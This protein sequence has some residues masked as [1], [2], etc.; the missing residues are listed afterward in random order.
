MKQHQ[1]LATLVAFSLCYFFNLQTILGQKNIS[2]K[3]ITATIDS[4][5]ADRMTMTTPGA[6][7]IILQGEKV[8]LSKDYG[9]ANLTFGV[10]FNENTVFPLEGLTEQ[11]VVFSILQLEKKKQLNLD[12]SVNKYLPELGFQD[13]V[14]LSHLLNHSSDLPFIASLRL[15]AGWKFSD[16]FTQEDF[17]NFTKKFSSNLSPDKE[18]RHS[19]SGIKILQMV[20]EKVAGRSFSEY[21]A[22]HIFAPL[23]MTNSTVKVENSIESKNSAVGY[24]KTDTGYLNVIVTPFEAHS[25]HTY[26]TRL[27]FQKWMAN[28]QSK[29]FEGAIFER[30]DESLFI[31]GKLQERSN[32][33]YCLGQH[34]YWK[35]LG[36][37]EFY[38][39]E[40]GNGFSWKWTRSTQSETSIMVVGNLDSYIGSKVNAIADLLVDYDTPISSDRK[41]TESAPLALSKRE[42]EACTGFYWNEDYL[43]TTEISIKDGQLYHSD[44]DNGFNF[45]MTPLTK[46]FF[47]T[48]FGGT[49]EFTNIG[50]NQK[51]MSN[52]LPDGRVFDSKQ[53][54]ASTL[55][56]GD[57]LKYEGIY[58]SDKLKAFYRVVWENNKLLLK[59]SRKANLELTPIGDHQFRT[60]EIDFRLIQFKE[61]IDGSFQKM[62]ISTMAL[63]DVE[64]RKL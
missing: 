51:K 46:T 27:D 37:D 28:Y 57:Q 55:K 36:Q 63:R 47:K 60:A 13:Q 25:P 9:A 49:L 43:Y 42:M 5:F 14:S 38:M 22:T 31:A 1:L 64:F 39:T 24:D 12:D 16:P 7:V 19:H 62:T 56:E 33:A 15:M 45:V 40:T 48:P 20:V 50:G 34:R 58:T 8:L 6:S 3:E 4:L 52:I 59:R 54:D 2:S 35:Y 61:S 53:Y 32:R 11:L 44:N 29:R 30:M 41:D 18:F 26:T 23:N 17:L 21:A 10:A